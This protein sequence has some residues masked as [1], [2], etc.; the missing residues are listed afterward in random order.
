VT[1]ANYDGIVY[2]INV[3]N[4]KLSSPFSAGMN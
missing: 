1:Y 3:C 2:S 4:R